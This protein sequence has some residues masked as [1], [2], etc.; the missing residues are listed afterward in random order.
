MKIASGADSGGGRAP[1]GI[2]HEQFWQE[3]EA[4]AGGETATLTGDTL[5]LV[6]ESLSA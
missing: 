5:T 3:V 6:L 1:G 2:P 4:E